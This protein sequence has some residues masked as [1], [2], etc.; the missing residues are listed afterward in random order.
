M[1]HTSLG[2]LKTRIRMTKRN[3][4]GTLM[5]H[6]LINPFKSFKYSFAIFSH[7]LLRWLSPLFLIFLSIAPFVFT[8]SFIFS[9]MPFKILIILIY[10]CGLLG[11]LFNIYGFKVFFFSQVYSF[12]LANIGFLLGITYFI[13]KS[14]KQTIY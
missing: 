5:F 12:I 10:I 13:F 7:K 4:K 8:G 1:K 14:K 11:F 6:S 3:L 9:L 2:E